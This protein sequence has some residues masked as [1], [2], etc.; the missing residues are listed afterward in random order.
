MCQPLCFI[1]GALL[2]PKNALL[3]EMMLFYYQIPDRLIDKDE[4]LYY[5]N[6]LLII[7]PTN[8]IALEFLSEQH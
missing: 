6:E 7:E 8:K 5:A 2:D 3:L 4:A 1:K